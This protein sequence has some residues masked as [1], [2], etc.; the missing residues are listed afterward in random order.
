MLRQLHFRQRGSEPFCQFADIIVRPEVHEEE[1]WLVIQHVI[2]QVPSL[3]AVR[4]Q[5]SQH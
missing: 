2:V 5:R 3:H 1:S 4:A